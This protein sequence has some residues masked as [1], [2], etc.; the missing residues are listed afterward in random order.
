MVFNAYSKYYNLLYKNKD[1]NSEVEYVDTLLKKFGNNKINSI[2]DIGCG[3]G[4]HDLIFAELGYDISGIDQSKAMLDIA[5]QRKGNLKNIS[6]IQENADTFSLDKKFDSV[7][8]LFHVMSYLTD[9]DLLLKT[10]KNVHTH[11]HSGG[12]FIFDFWYGPAVLSEKPDQR[13]KKMENNSVLVYRTVNP[14][15]KSEIN[16]VDV[17]YEV[18]VID[19]KSKKVDILKEKHSMRYFFLPEIKLMLSCIGFDVLI[20]LDWMQKDK[21]P[22]IDSWNACVVARKK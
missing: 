10:F 6:F 7:I 17:N 19:K 2:I 14:M 1:Y 16:V 18:L 22:N 8:S 15:L 13:I 21:A 12:L 4:S 11:L 20:E 5:E 3:T 9:T